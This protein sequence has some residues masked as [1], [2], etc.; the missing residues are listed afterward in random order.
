ML[1]ILLLIT[2][3]LLLALLLVLLILLRRPAAGAGSD[4]LIRFEGLKSSIETVDRL[5]RDESA[6][7]REAF[8]RSAQ[9]DREELQRALRSSADSLQSRIAEIAS[10]QRGQLDSFA[11]QL[12]AVSQTTGEKLDRVRDLSLIHI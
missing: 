4:L 3:A 12:S 2:L 1:E 7:S 5:L 11:G 6:R 8:E 9:Q 10:L